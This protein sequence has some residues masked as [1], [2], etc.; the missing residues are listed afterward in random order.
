MLRHCSGLMLRLQGGRIRKR[1]TAIAISHAP[2]AL[3]ATRAAHFKGKGHTSKLAEASR[4]AIVRRT[5]T[6]SGSHARLVEPRPL[7]WHHRAICPPI[8]SIEASLLSPK[9]KGYQGTC[10]LV[11]RANKRAGTCLGKRG[12][13]DGQGTAQGTRGHVRGLPICLCLP[14]LGALGGPGLAPWG[15]RMNGHWLTGHAPRESA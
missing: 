12:G 4:R 5:L 2:R 6:A 14:P 3:R 8:L 1:R 15:R 9:K 7:T 13:C 10:H 11:T